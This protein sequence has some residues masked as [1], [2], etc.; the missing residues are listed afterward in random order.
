MSLAVRCPNKECGRLVRVS[1]ELRGQRISCPACGAGLRIPSQKKPAAVSAEP[2]AL[3]DTPPDLEAIVASETPAAAPKGSKAAQVS[4]HVAD[5]AAMVT[6]AISPLLKLAIV[7]AVLAALAIVG[8]LY[9]F[10][11]LWAKKPISTGTTG[12]LTEEEDAARKREQQRRANERPLSEESKVAIRSAIEAG[13][14]SRARA[15]L[16]GLRGDATVSSDDRRSLDLAYRA[17]LDR[18]LNERFDAAQE[19]LAVRNWEG[20]ES[21]LAAARQLETGATSLSRYQGL[22]NSVRSGRAEDLIEQS[23]QHAARKEFDE[24]LQ[25]ANEARTLDKRNK[26]FGPWLNELTRMMGAGIRFKL[27]GATADVYMMDD[28]SGNKSPTDQLGNTARTI[29]GIG[30]TRKQIYRLKAAGYVPRELKANARGA[31]PTEVPVSLVPAAPDALWVAHLFKE[32][33]VRWLACRAIPAEH[34]AVA[35]YARKLEQKC[36]SARVDEKKRTVWRVRPAGGKA[37]HALEY[38]ALGNTVRYVELETG[39]TVRTTADKI[40]RADKLDVQEG[41]K[42]RLAAMGAQAASAE[43]RCDAYRA[44]GEFV[45]LYPDQMDMVIKE[46]GDKLATWGRELATVVSCA[47]QNKHKDDMAMG[48]RISVETAAWQEAGE[49]PP[50]ALL[51]QQQ[52]APRR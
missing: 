46:Y 3:D 38:S 18:K 14:L 23:R 44:L 2:V 5:K 30:S 34:P 9:I 17:A 29:W 51:E 10:P 50:E 43:R 40:E 47:E 52:N 13:D 42:R 35:A 28:K 49:E 45:E 19:K 12:V 39:E 15:L 37:V 1:A 26:T 16:D 33:A 31:S 22:E 6:S 11:M 8:P 4:E 32:P 20:V 41:A 48:D 25:A 24:A 7:L 36:Q 27:E 21:E